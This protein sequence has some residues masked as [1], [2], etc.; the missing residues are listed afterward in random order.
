[1]FPRLIRLPQVAAAMAQRTT[2]IYQDV[3]D[4]V[5]P[6]PIHKGRSSF[7]VESEIAAVN[8]A[9]IAGRTE[10][11]IRALV[12]EL[13]A[14]RG[15]MAEKLAP[16]SAPATKKTARTARPVKIRRGRNTAQAGEA[17]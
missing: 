15:Q 4:G 1:M 10:D 7:W 3:K 16:T 8:A 5:L 17:A 2:A 12:S 14:Q 11:E 13:V 9:R 6:R